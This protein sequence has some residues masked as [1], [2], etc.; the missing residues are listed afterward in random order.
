MAGR[1]RGAGS[2]GVAAG[3]SRLGGRALGLLHW[4]TLYGSPS[5][6][7]KQRG[8]VKFWA[9]AIGA[10]RV[11]VIAVAIAVAATPIPPWPIAH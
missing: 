9:W 6:A 1:L 10:A 11:V 8:M 5:A 2:L 3:S 4:A 7:C